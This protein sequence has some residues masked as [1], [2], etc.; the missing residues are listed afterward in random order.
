VLDQMDLEQKL[1]KGEFK[2]QMDQMAIQLGDLH[3]KLH[4][5]GIPVIIV[6]EGW[7]A[8][9]R[10]TLINELILRLDPRGFKVFANNL[11]HGDIEAYPFAW[12]YW[13]TSPAAGKIM[14]YD[15]SWYEAV[16]AH[17]ID[18]LVKDG[19]VAATYDAIVSFE[20][21]LADSGCIMIKFFLH[22]TKK[23]QKSRLD[24]LEKDPATR[25]R[26]SDVE[27]RRHRKY[28]EYL[29][30]VE[31]TLSRTDRDY[32]PWTLVSAMDRRF[33]ATKICGKVIQVLEQRVQRVESQKNAPS[34]QV[35]NPAIS[36]E[37]PT[38]ALEKVVIPQDWKPDLYEKELSRLG[39]KLHELHYETY[40]K[41]IPVLILFEGWD[42]AGKGGAIKRLVGNFDPRGYEVVPIAA[43]NDT[44]REHHYLWRFWRAVP[45][46]GRIA[47][48]DRT[49]YGRVLV[50]RVEGFCPE[51]DWRRAY[52]EINEFEEQLTN[53][54]GVVVKFWLHID[55]DEQLRRFEERENTP[56]K[57]WKITAEDWR[58]REK[59]DA[60]KIAVD[61]MLFRTSTRKAPWTVVA[62]N[63]KEYA[64]L[65]VL[66]T[67]ADAMEKA[68]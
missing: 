67:V 66:K 36:L 16:M 60:Y 20:R 54:G 10:G 28:D 12:P 43:P 29:A 46:A 32:S 26:V 63:S 2:T 37:V 21:Q 14:I 5:F 40:K 49:W 1:S 56:A 68:L 52:R 62:A 34:S 38:S 23:E 61:E 11:C 17:R 30:I 64:R 18:G 7:D 57:K 19:K 47:V 42:A 35:S 51:T 24:D 9:G 58:N 53:F 44:E 27:W 22:I 48:F 41:K 15:K 4:D 45:A 8:A 50:E 31:E 39:N 3:R 55:K 33:A 13:N 25:W 65:T 6:F 59:W